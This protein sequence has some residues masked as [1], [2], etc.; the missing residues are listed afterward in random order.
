MS[1]FLISGLA[2]SGKST[3]VKYVCDNYKN[4]VEL[5]LADKLKHMT[6]KLLKLFD[7][8]IGSIGE[9]Y[10]FS[11]KNKYRKYLQV[12]GTEIFKESLGE[13]IWCELIKDSVSNMLHNNINVFI[14]DIRFRHEIHYFKS[15]FIDL[16]DVKTIRVKSNKQLHLPNE[17]NNHSSEL[18][19]NNTDDSCYD[20]VLYNNYDDVFYDDI[21]KEICVNMDRL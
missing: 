11:T 13:N 7:I 8:D 1:L 12:I 18:D 10:E 6:Y 20:V 14:S 19:L 9:L 21:D 2:Q 4:C 16:Y 15:N 5:A 17:L 3:L